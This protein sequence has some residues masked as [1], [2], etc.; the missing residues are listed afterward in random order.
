MVTSS[1]SKDYFEARARFCIAAQHCGARLD[2]FDCPAEGPR[3][4]K[5]STDIA[6]LGDAAATKVLVVI[7]GT[8]GVEGFCGSA[9]QLDWLS[10]HA[11]TALPDGTAMLLIHAINPYGFAWLRRCTQEGVDLNRNFIDSTRPAPENP[12][13][14][15]IADALLPTSLTGLVARAADSRLA[16]Y[17]EKVGDLAY[18]RTVASGQYKHAD[19][20]F[21]GGGGPT[22]SYRTTQEIIARHLQGRP[23][24]A[25]VDFHT[26]LGPFGYGEPITDYAVGSAGSD[27]VRAFWGDSVTESAKGQTLPMVKD[28][29]THYGYQ[30]ALPDSRVTFA[31]L[32]FGTYD[33][34]S[35]RKALRA[36]HWLHKHGDPLG[37]EAAPIRQALR[38]Q[39][40]P[41][42]A[43]WKESVLFRGH[44]VV[45][46]AIDGLNGH[47]AETGRV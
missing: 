14:D 35:G 42:T 34:D 11:S 15:E 2:A 22:W 45:R 30:R 8:H 9:F 21:Y 27:R 17:R 40:F 37:P 39:Y 41:D 12:G 26:G 33:R 28:G 13:Y 38:R 6:W 36:D 23:D 16:T 43:D 44:Q 32:E 46:M 18:F 1:F 31:T 3:G 47:Y 25:V 4:E 20:M 5:L 10:A 7:S 29:S 24:V 19:G